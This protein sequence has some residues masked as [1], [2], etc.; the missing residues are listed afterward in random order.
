MTPTRSRMITGGLAALVAT[1]LTA[2]VP[3]MAQAAPPAFTVVAG[4]LNNPRHLSFTDNGDLYVAESGT[5]GTGP[6]LMG[7]EGTEVCYGA[8]G[9]ITRLTMR[10][11]GW[12]QQRVVTGLPSLAPPADIPPT[13]DNPQGVQKGSQA[14]GPSDVEVRGSKFVSSIGLGSDPANRGAGM[15]TDPTNGGPATLPT[16]FGTLIQGSVFGAKAGGWSVLAD[17]AGQ[18]AA[19]NPIDNPDSNPA[20]VLRDG[21]QYVVADAGGNTVVSSDHQGRMQTLAGFPDVMSPFAGG[22]IPTQFVPTSVVKGPDGAYYVSQLTGFPF[23]AGGASI[24]RLVPGQAPTKYATGLT[25]ITDLA[26]GADG[27][28]YAVEISEGGLATTGPV[29]ALVRI[30]AGGGSATPVAQGL[31]APYGLALR[32]GDAYV[33]TGSVAPG[34]G[35][36]IKVPLR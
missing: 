10:G 36:V 23:P 35:E 13:E 2:A 20:S 19:T 25:N 14:T 6:C 12:S 30:P 26:F 34:G 9:S 31:F 21:S 7:G 33:T 32:G 8:T 4:G 27:T 22:T 15:V 17:I 28:L 29:G 24:W 1:G 11:A 5:G 18:E 3:V 16:G